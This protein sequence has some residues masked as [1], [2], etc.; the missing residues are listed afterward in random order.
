MGDD[1]STIQRGIGELEPDLNY[2]SDN[3]DFF[4]QEIKMNAVKTAHVEIQRTGDC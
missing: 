2:E 4:A 1:W 3:W